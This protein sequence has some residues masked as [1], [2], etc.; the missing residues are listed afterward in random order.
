MNKSSQI[1]KN[2][3][4][5]CHAIRQNK[6][7]HLRSILCVTWP[8]YTSDMTYLHV[9]HDW[10]LVHTLI[11]Q[12]IPAETGL[13]HVCDTTH[14]Y[15]KKNSFLH[16]SISPIMKCLNDA[17]IKVSHVTNTIESCYMHITKKKMWH[18]CSRISPI[19]KWPNDVRIK[20]NYATN[21]S[22]SCHVHINKKKCSTCVAEHLDLES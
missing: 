19:M 3:N 14:P 13:S 12:H 8:I 18:L 11:L 22:E 9:W 21:M 4:T 15:A 10:L 17:R 6:T 1:Y 20:M 7:W 2:M 16:S 5:S